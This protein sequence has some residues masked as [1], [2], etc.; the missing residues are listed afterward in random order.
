MWEQGLQLLVNTYLASLSSFET[1][2]FTKDNLAS[3]RFKF[4]KAIVPLPPYLLSW[5][6]KS[7]TQWNPG[8]GESWILCSRKSAGKEKLLFGRNFWSLTAHSFAY[9]HLKL[10]QQ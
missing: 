7:I 4:T 2:H 1:I 3:Q 5:K 8:A 9:D 10:I 6:D